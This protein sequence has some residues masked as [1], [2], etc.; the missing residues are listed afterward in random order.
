MFRRLGEGAA[1]VREA[2]HGRP[3]EKRLQASLKLQ[4]RRIAPGPSRLAFADGSS[5][6]SIQLCIKTVA[7]FAS[8]A[9]TLK[10]HHEGTKSQSSL[11]IVLVYPR[12]C[13]SIFV[14]FIFWRGE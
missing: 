11:F 6:V 4:A 10:F 12:L 13:G 1:Q 2:I 9:K 8:T 3:A 7:Y 14:F 5:E